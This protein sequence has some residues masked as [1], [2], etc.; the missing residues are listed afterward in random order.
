MTFEAT[1]PN[2]SLPPGPGGPR[3]LQTTRFL[4][5][6][7]RFLKHNA[8]RFGDY[9]TVHLPERTI[10]ISSDPE[11]V[12]AAFTGPSD[13]LLAGVGN[14]VLLPILGQ[15][16]LL[17]LDGPEHLRQRKLLLPAFH[18]ER[19]QAFGELIAEATTRHVSRWPLGHSFAAQP[20]MQAITLEVIMRAVFGVRDRDEARRMAAP[21]G[22]LLN[23]LSSRRRLL[24]L[25]LGDSSNPRPGSAWARMRRLTSL[26]DA[27]I[28]EQIRARRQRPGDTNDVLGLLL[29]ATDE[30]GQELSDRELRDELMTMLLAGHET[31]ATAL[32]WSLELLSRH[33]DVFDQLAAEDADP[34]AAGTYLEAVVNESL[35]L[36]PVVPAVARYLKTPQRIGPWSLPAGV[37]LTPS[38]YLVHRRPDLYPDPERFDPER[39][40]G[41]RPGGYEWIPF[42]GGIRRCLG[43]AFA[44]YE[45]RVILKTI[46]DNTLLAPRR[47]PEATTRRAIVFA[48]AHGGRISLVARNV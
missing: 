34:A 9:F 17:L 40:L 43:A 19:I 35:R 30:H 32:A 46:V 15:G 12:K 37:H 14:N 7:T 21:L 31:T 1:A 11:A 13:E 3:L 41:K 16:S 26:A 39:F 24:A 2:S 45:M 33:P 10:I 4:L 47:R 36:R 44:L 29:A 5:Q 28:Y 48:P 38:I 22:A 8:A 23:E 6:P 20:S 25:Q 18:G 27:V 42:G